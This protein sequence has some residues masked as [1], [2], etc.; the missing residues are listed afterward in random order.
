MEPVSKPLSSRA[1]RIQTLPML[2]A[3][4]R[5]L[6]AWESPDGR[7]LGAVLKDLTDDDFNLVVHVCPTGTGVAAAADLAVSLATLDDA[8][9]EL[10][11]RMNKA[12][13]ALPAV[14]AAA[15]EDIS[16]DTGFSVPT[17]SADTFNVVLAGDLPHITMFPDFTEFT[18]PVIIAE[19]DTNHAGLYVV[20]IDAKTNQYLLQVFLLLKVPASLGT[21]AP[22]AACP[23]ARKLGI[24]SLLEAVAAG[25]L[26]VRY[27][28]SRAVDQGI[29]D[30]DP[31]NLSFPEEKDLLPFMTEACLDHPTMSYNIERGS[32]LRLRI[33]LVPPDAGRSTVEI[34]TVPFAA[35]NRT[36]PYPA[37][38][39]LAVA[40]INERQ[41]E[42]RIAIQR[43]IKV[44]DLIW[45]PDDIPAFAALSIVDRSDEG[46]LA[47]VPLDPSFDPIA[48]LRAPVAEHRKGHRHCFDA[49]LY[50]N[51]GF[52]LKAP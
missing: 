10:F 32:V 4:V 16:T 21:Y 26:A 22:T 43:P 7:V 5:E 51:T 9:T 31:E 27:W 20:S 15:S 47:V 46:D 18:G 25:R 13:E 39:T 6:E 2:A 24:P 3:F 44:G 17:R 48:W 50:R 28:T 36:L 52:P 41:A 8:R 23:A 19:R 37:V 33:Q 35:K 11:A 42:G 45:G 34:H 38:A 1:S 14:T 30:L 12:W 49:G 29:E 40:A